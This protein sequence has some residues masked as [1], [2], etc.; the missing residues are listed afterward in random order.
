MA[1]MN[2]NVLNDFIAEKMK[3]M[4]DKE[5]SANIEKLIDSKYNY[6]KNGLDYE[7][8]L[9]E[10]SSNSCSVCKK[11]EVELDKIKK[12]HADEINVVFINTTLPENQQLIKYMGIPAIPLQVILDKKGE[13]IFKHYGFISAEDLLAVCVKI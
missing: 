11:M 1:F 9:F 5:T 4:V 10:F 2:K 12:S 3:T 6:S 7:F 8:T 13:E